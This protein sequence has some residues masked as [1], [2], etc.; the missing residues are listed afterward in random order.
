MFCLRAFHFFLFCFLTLEWFPLSSVMEGYRSGG[1]LSEELSR[2]GDKGRR[3]EKRRGKE[4]RSREG[5]GGEERREEERKGGEESRGEQRVWMRLM[6]RMGP[7]NWRWMRAE[8]EAGKPA[9]MLWLWVVKYSQCWASP[10]WL[11]GSRQSCTE[12]AE[13]ATRWLWTKMFQ[14]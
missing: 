5:Q 10:R 7:S 6:R 12:A 13:K 3:G 8:G 11:R 2:R 4:E 14:Q 9:V 1:G